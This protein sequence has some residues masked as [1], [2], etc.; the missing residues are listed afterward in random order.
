MTE[1]IYQVVIEECLG[2]SGTVKW[3]WEIFGEQNL[4]ADGHC[5]SLTEC[6]DKL[7]EVVPEL[8]Q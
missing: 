2:P 7:R 4:I 5:D 6:V 8:Q 3:L 1:R